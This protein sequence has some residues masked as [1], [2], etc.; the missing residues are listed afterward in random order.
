MLELD[1]VVIEAELGIGAVENALRIGFDGVSDEFLKVDVKSVDN[2]VCIVSKM[3]GADLTRNLILT[4]VIELWV[5]VVER[6][7]S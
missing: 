3:I 4:V 6:I 1:A 7:R 5:P 2:L